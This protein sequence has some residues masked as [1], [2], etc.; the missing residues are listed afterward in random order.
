MD[1]KQRKNDSKSLS[2]IIFLILLCTPIFSTEKFQYDISKNEKRI[3]EYKS[4]IKELNS[5]LPEEL[6]LFFKYL[7]NDYAVFYDWNGEE[8][9]FKYRKNKFDTNSYEKT[10]GLYSGQSY[11]VKG[12]FIGIA[13]FRDKKTNLYLQFPIFY[14]K[15]ISNKNDTFD[16]VYD[17]KEL[18]LDQLKDKDSILVYELNSF[19]STAIDELIY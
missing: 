4:E 8:V 3:K 15:T 7:K 2:K 12:K 13:S 18:S 10:L 17:F 1:D 5:E 6:K 16:T 9:F 14:F 19:E 11:R